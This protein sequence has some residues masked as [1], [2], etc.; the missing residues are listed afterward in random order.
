[1]NGYLDMTQESLVCLGNA[2]NFAKVKNKQSALT[3]K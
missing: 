1:M 2:L 3:E